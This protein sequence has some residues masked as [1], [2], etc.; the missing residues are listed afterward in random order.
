MTTRA[1][2]QPTPGSAGNLNS[3]GNLS[4]EHPDMRSTKP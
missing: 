4:A 3:A 1:G 2:P